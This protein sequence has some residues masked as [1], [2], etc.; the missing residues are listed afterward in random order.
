MRITVI[1]KTTSSWYP[2]SWKIWN[3]MEGFSSNF[4][5]LKIDVSIWFGNVFFSW[6]KAVFKWTMQFWFDGILAPCQTQDEGLAGLGVLCQACRGGSRLS[7]GHW[8]PG[9]GQL[10]S[11]KWVKSW[12]DAFCY[13]ANNSHFPRVLQQIVS[14]VSFLILYNL[15]F[16]SLVIPCISFLLF[17]TCTFKFFSYWVWQRA[18]WAMQ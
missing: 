16:W 15:T 2:G 8:S 5:F 1:R 4:M 10:G 3:L 12:R 9:A 13:Y 18:L 6:K 11:A 14:A 7:R 17:Q